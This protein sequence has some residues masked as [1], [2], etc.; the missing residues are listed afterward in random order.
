M[1]LSW[2]APV[3]ACKTRPLTR[4]GSPHFEY[5]NPAAYTARVAQTT[6]GEN[7]VSIVRIGLAETKGFGEGFD[8]IFGKKEPA[9]A[10]KKP[11]KAK[12]VKAKKKGKKK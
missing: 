12:T 9:P 4:P 10:P 1:A 11:A 6:S 5:N 8:A 2:Q 3:K 7:N